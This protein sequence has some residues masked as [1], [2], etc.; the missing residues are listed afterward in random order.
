MHRE[1]L[2]PLGAR[3][4]VD[5]WRFQMSRFF[6]SVLAAGVLSGCAGAPEL[7]VDAMVLFGLLVMRGI[8]EQTVDYRR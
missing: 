4:S 3:R 2:S 5:N 7:V 1:A 8:S 6:V